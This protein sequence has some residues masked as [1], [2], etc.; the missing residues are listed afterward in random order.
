MIQLDAEVVDVARE[1]GRDIVSVRFWGLVREQ[2]EAG[3]EA[4][5]EVWH[6]VRP[7]TGGDWAIAG[8]NPV[9]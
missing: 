6:L 2:A 4:F 9:Q 3:A 5:N 7:S 8:I 1:D